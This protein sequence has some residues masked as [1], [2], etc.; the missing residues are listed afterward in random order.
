MTTPSPSIWTEPQADTADEAGCTP[1]EFDEIER[2]VTRGSTTGR[3]FRD[4]RFAVGD[5]LVAKYGPPGKPGS[6][7]ATEAQLDVL[8]ARLKLSPHTLRKCRLLAHRWKP[9]QRQPV[10]DSPVHVS[11][12]TMFQ[13]A[14]SSEHGE[15]DQE[16]FNEKVEVLLGLM[17]LAAQHDILEVTETDYLKAVRKAVPPSRRPG[18]QSEHKA[19]VTTVT[20]FEARQPDVRDAV[21]GAVK[22]DEDATRSVAAAYLMRRPELARAVLRE[23]PE[24]A[25]AAAQEAALH[26]PDAEEADGESG[27]QVFRELVQVLGGARPSD[28][29]LLAEW[30][31]DFARAVGRFNAFV[32][33][34]YPADKVAVNADAD[35]V[36]LVTYLADDVARWAATI[37]DSRTPGGLRLVES[38]TA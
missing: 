32:T 13:V 38:T 15:F 34:W 10:L 14:L 6:R 21:L 18:A 36:R 20:Q 27:E 26:T 25:E 2:I 37:T 22:A 5:W 3:E 31:Q 23:D 1:A 24:L 28:E 29:L 19:V 35:I 33:D 4:T 17:D 11:F 30:R 7:Y 12:T 8:S 16:Q 9:Q